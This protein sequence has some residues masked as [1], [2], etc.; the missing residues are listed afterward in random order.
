MPSTPMR[1]QFV[2]EFDHFARVVAARA[3]EHRHLALGFF[4]RDLDDA[5]VFGAA[6]RGAFAGGAAG[7]QEI[8]PGVDLP[9]HQPAQRRFVE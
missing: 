6:Q 2:R 3:G 5:Q 4:E 8:D 1:F 7:H 9:A